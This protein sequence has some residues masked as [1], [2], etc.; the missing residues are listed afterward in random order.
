MAISADDQKRIASAIHAAEQ[1]TCG[2]IVCVLARK[3]SDYAFVAVI[4]AAL[5]ALASPWPMIALTQMPVERIFA[6]QI[7]AFLV[8][9]AV[10]AWPPVR[11]RLVPEPV[12]RAHAHVAAMEQFMTRGLGRKTHGT[13]VLI[14]VS[15]A[16]RYVRIIAD[17][18]IAELV[19]QSEWQ[20]AVDALIPH[21]RDGRIADGFVAAIARC[22]SVLARHFPPRPEDKGELPDR[23]YVI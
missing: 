18:K 16:E 9:L 1:Q 11:I 7:A 23:I 8:L 5:I 20:A 3:S 10:F 4:W 15:L 17:E 13:A 22:G 2:E 12:A 14:F 6:A 19:P 21:M